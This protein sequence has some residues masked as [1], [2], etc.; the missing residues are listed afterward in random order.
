MKLGVI[1]RP[2]PCLI[3]GFSLVRVAARNHYGHDNDSGTAAAARSFGPQGSKTA[4]RGVFDRDRLVAPLR[5]SG[6][7]R[8]RQRRH[9]PRLISG[10]SPLCARFLVIWDVAFVRQPAADTPDRRDDIRIIAGLG[11]FRG[12]QSPNASGRGRLPVGAPKDPRT[13]SEQQFVT[14]DGRFLV[15]FAA[16]VRFCLVPDRSRATRSRTHNR[17]SS[18]V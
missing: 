7:V 17:W 4:G 3:S 6:Q 5:E 13:P 14:A 11:A 2:A 10:F 18:R 1:W 15:D 9:E 16:S 12:G 8:G